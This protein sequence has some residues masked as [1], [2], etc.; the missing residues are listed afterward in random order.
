MV[1]SGMRNG[2]T[3]MVTI[4]WSVSWDQRVRVSKLVRNLRLPLAGARGALLAGPHLERDR[5][6]VRQHEQDGRQG[7]RVPEVARR[8]GRLRVDHRA[9]ELRR[10]GGA[11]LGQQPRPVEE[12]QRGHEAVSYTHLT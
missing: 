4:T 12:L 8:A 6:P 7:R 10:V 11:A 1:T 9:E 2:I 5:H 3:A